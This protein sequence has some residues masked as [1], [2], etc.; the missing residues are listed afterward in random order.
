M[1]EPNKCLHVHTIKTSNKETV[2]VV[3]D[4]L[5]PHFLVTIDVFIFVSVT[6]VNSNIYRSFRTLAV[7]RLLFVIKNSYVSFC[8]ERIN[9]YMI[10][11]IV[12]TYL[13]FPSIAEAF[14]N[15]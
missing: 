9:F 12:N 1:D 14:L 6:A 10:I 2:E 5:S 7:K 4:L 11:C 15:Y 13:Y 8:F 3:Y